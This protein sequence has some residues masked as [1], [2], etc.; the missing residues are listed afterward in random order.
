MLGLEDLARRIEY[1]RDGEHRDAEVV[2]MTPGGRLLELLSLSW[3]SERRVWVL[4]TDR[5]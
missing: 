5:R 4:V 1:D 2:V 3:D